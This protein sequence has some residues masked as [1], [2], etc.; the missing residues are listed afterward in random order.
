MEENSYVYLVAPEKNIR[1]LRRCIMMTGIFGLQK[2][3]R[4]EIHGFI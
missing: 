2:D 3:V 1:S 4:Q